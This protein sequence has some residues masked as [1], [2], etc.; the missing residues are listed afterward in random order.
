[1]AK[2]PKDLETPL[3]KESNLHTQHDSKNNNIIFTSFIFSTKTQ[4]LHI[5]WRK[6]KLLKNGELGC[7]GGG[8]S[9]EGLV[10]GAPGL[11]LGLEDP[12]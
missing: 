1:M 6:K 8:S 3:K 7:H 2:S 11:E 12:L 4:A 10:F 5:F 9:T